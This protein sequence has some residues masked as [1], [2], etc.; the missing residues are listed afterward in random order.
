MSHSLSDNDRTLLSAYMDG[1]VSADEIRD[2]ERLLDGSEEARTYLEHLHAVQGFSVQAFPALPVGAATGAALGKLSAGAISAAAKKSALIK[3]LTLGPWG[4]VG[5]F[6]AA[7]SVAVGVTVAVQSHNTEGK[8]A[9]TAVHRTISRAAM[10]PAPVNVDTSSLIVPPMT[11]SEVVRFAVDGIVPIDSKRSQFLALAS[12]GRDSIMVSLH[13]RPSEDFNSELDEID[14]TRWQELDSVHRAIRTALLQYKNG[15]IA[16]RCDIPALRLKALEHVERLCQQ[17]PVK[18]QEDLV[19]VRREVEASRASIQ[20]EEAG[21]RRVQ[22]QQ[23]DQIPYVVLSL[24]D[25]N[26]NGA[27][28]PIPIPPTPPIPPSPYER[29]SGAVQ[30]VVISGTSLDELRSVAPSA[31]GERVQAQAYATGNLTTRRVEIRQR[32]AARAFNPTGELPSMRVQIQQTEGPT[33]DSNEALNR[34]LQQAQSQQYLF[35]NGQFSIQI[36]NDSLIQS[37]QHALDAADSTLRQ[38]D[39]NLSKI[40]VRIVTPPRPAVFFGH[41]DSTAAKQR[42]NEPNTSEPQSEQGGSGGDQ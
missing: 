17:L 30:F 19:S 34:L 32:P 31:I 13:S 16:I 37:I 5:V 4:T 33:E 36:N 11:P 10:M 21:M 18:I 3:G 7:A 9:A 27:P 35:R 40:P 20:A 6:A 42:W 39:W 28:E 15:G 24:D 1:E 38:I 23:G 14:P 2:A 8:Y 22:I 29:P 25:L 26:E 41:P 12:H